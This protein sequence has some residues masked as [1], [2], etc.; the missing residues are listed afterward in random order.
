M[1]KAM[2]KDFEV[3]IAEM[4]E[5]VGVKNIKLQWEYVVT[6]GMQIMKWERRGWEKIRRHLC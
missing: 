2:Q 1:K 3:T 6:Q 4:L 5:K